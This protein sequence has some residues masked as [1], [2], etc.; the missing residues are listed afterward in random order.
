MRIAPEP[1]DQRPQQQLLGEAHARV[2]RHLERAELDQAEPPGRP[3]GREQLVD[4]Q[5]GPMGV[6]GH[7]HQ[8]VAEQA[9]DQPRPRRLAGSRRRHHRERDLELVQHVLPR[10]VDARRL[11]GRTDEQAGEEIGQRRAPLPVEHQ[12]LEQIGPPQERAVGRRHA[13][14]HHVIAA[15]GAG[16][17]A[18]DHE[19]VGAEPREARLLVERGRGLDRFAPGRGRVD[20]DL[21]HARIGRHLDDADARIVRGR[22]AL[23][24]DRNAKLRG[25][26]FGGG[27][28]LEIVLEPLD[29][30]HEHAQLAVAR[31]DRERGA[32]R[33]GWRPAEP[34]PAWLA[35]PDDRAPAP[36]RPLR[37]PRARR[38]AARPACARSPPVP[39]RGGGRAMVGAARTDRPA[40]DADSRPAPDRAASSAAGAGRSANRRAPGTGGRGASATA[41]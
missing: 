34:G 12:A 32:N 8:E 10:L 35:A 14:E 24:T 2:G 3:V 13:A 33:N 28:K 9:I 38:R 11:A 27:E 21:D 20:V 40:P 25:G 29:R 37:P 7:V 41:R 17:A 18:V 19:L 22:I 31:L 39:R 23:Q 15:A 26:R 4:A 16:V 5:L 1:G 36:P 6:A 30:R